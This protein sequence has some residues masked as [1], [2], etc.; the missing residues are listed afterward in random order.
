MLNASEASDDQHIPISIVSNSSILR[1]GLAKLLSECI[2][3]RLIGIYTSEADWNDSVLNPTGHMIMLDTGI[4]LEQ[5]IAC[6]QFWRT[7]TPPAHVIVLELVNDVN[8]IIQCIEAGASGYSL[9]GAPIDEVAAVMRRVRQGEVTCSPEVTAQLFARLEARSKENAPFTPPGIP[10]TTRELEVLACIAD[11]MSNR[12]I[13]DHLVIAVHT[14]KHHIHSIL[15]KLELD[16]RRE[17]ARLA[18]RRGWIGEP[19]TEQRL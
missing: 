17:A 4:G 6:T 7:R 11:G 12:E 3:I 16:H 14:V 18:I 9:Q 19:R 5:A 1:E 8:T 15:T 13:A 10:L 2:D